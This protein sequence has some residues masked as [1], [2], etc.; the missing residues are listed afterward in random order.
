MPLD[1]AGSR[2]R[3]DLESKGGGLFAEARLSALQSLLIILMKESFSVG[4]FGKQHIVQDSSNLVG[5][6]CDGLCSPEF[7]P[8]ATKEFAEV[9]FCT[10]KRICPDAKC[11]SCS[12]LHFAC[13]AGKNLTATDL[14]FWAEAEP[15]SKC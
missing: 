5:R 9:T 4:L 7:G 8:H 12:I 10:T 14:F 2:V 11:N 15:R 13:F 6:C 1:R 3:N